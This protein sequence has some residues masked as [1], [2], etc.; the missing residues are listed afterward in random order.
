MTRWPLSL[1]L[2]T[3][4]VTIAACGDTPTAPS[5][6][7]AESAAQSGGAA[8]AAPMASSNALGPE[9]PPFNNEVVLRPVDD[10]GGIRP[11]QVPPAE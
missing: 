8:A 3:L 2:S 7:E 4:I 11:G 6:P 5:R 10:G 1:A 9:T